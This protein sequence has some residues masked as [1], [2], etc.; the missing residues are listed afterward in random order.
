MF[1]RPGRVAHRDRA[2]KLVSVA[3]ETVPPSAGQP[4]RYGSALELR[5]RTTSY[6]LSTWPRR[7]R[8]TA[9]AG[10]EGSRTRARTRCAS[11]SPCRSGCSPVRLAFSKR[12]SV[13][14]PT[15]S[16]ATFRLTSGSSIWKDEW[17][18]SRSRRPFAE[19][20][21]PQRVRRGEGLRQV[22]TPPLEERAVPVMQGDRVYRPIAGGTHGPSSH[23]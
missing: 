10:L 6:R 21:Q 23:T 5:S 19:R 12:W 22:R 3:E 2:R 14:P 16:A 20:A 17:T 4:G 13:R 1:G 7:R 8:K 11:S 15:R 18:R 9:V